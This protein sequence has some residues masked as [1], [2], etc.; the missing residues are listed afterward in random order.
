MT[1]PSNPDLIRATALLERKPLKLPQ[2]I[3]AQVQQ[4]QMNNDTN[5]IQIS[6]KT[7]LRLQ[8]L[9]RMIAVHKRVRD[10]YKDAIPT[11][12]DTIHRLNYRLRGATTED[13]RLELAT[14]VA[15]MNAQLSEKRHDI[16]RIEGAIRDW[17]AERAE[18]LAG[19]GIGT[20]GFLEKR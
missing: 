14:E 1:N 2:V 18:I 12:Q 19:L 8:D 5:H 15:S 6:E 9:D 16:W 10:S 20:G 3:T 11:L 13:R 4:S 17:E 7:I